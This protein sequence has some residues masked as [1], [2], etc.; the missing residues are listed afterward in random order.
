[1][2]LAHLKLIN[3]NGALY[4]QRFSNMVSKED[5]CKNNLNI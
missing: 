2:Q 5:I 1:M 3:G 4:M